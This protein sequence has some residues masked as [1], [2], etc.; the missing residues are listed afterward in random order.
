MPDSTPSIQDPLE[1]ALPLSSWKAAARDTVLEAGKAAEEFRVDF[2][3]FLGQ[4]SDPISWREGL[5]LVVDG[6]MGLLKDLQEMVCTNKWSLEQ[7]VKHMDGSIEALVEKHPELIEEWDKVKVSFNFA[8]LKTNEAMTQIKA[9]IDQKKISQAVWSGIKG[10]IKAD[11]VHIMARFK[12]KS[13][14]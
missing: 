5:K 3:N 1:E 10:E 8:K 4:L 2:K 11:I 7:L 13:D 14:V 12:G 6:G 9:R